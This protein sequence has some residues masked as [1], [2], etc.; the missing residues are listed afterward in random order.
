M[1]EVRQEMKSYS[2]MHEFVKSRL[3]LFQILGWGQVGTL[4]GS[5]R[6]VM[7]IPFQLVL[8]GLGIATTTLLLQ[9]AK[10]AMSGKHKRS[11]KH[12]DSPSAKE[13]RVA[14]QMEPSTVVDSNPT[15]K[16]IAAA[17]AAR[18]R[19][20]GDQTNAASVRSTLS[21]HA[22]AAMCAGFV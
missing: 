14:Q 4:L 8:L 16:E 13:P 22:G 1:Q 12:G 11:P 6:R 17:E 20:H 15:Q 2:R 3:K 10:R 21:L 18:A 9:G 5:C 7:R 19:L